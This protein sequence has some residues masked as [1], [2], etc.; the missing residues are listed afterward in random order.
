MAIN[1]LITMFF[2]LA[3]LSAFS[4]KAGIDKKAKK[5]SPAPGLAG[6]Y[7]GITNC[8]NCDGIETTLILKEENKY[9][10]ATKAAHKKEKADMAEGTFYQK[11]GNIFLNGLLPGQASVYWIKNNVAKQLY[12]ING[13]LQGADW[14]HYSLFKIG[15]L[16]FKDKPLK[17]RMLNR[18]SVDE[19][20]DPVFVTFM[21]KQPFVEVHQ[22]CSVSFINYA[23]RNGVQFEAIPTL[24]NTGLQKCPET[25]LATRIVNLIFQADNIFIE[26]G[27]L[28]LR[29]GAGWPLIRFEP[30]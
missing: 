21:S 15:T 12:M 16:P 14:E 8:A 25:E 3:N 2:I 20:A 22:G 5:H 29:R 7:F 11:D 30:D 28:S 6:T 19:G 26:N 18:D 23:I 24:N 1:R 13:S 9:I 4:Q 27:E 17:V 10:L